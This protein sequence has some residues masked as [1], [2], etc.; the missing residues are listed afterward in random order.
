[1]KEQDV[2]LQPPVDLVGAADLGEAELGRVMLSGRA[3]SRT[4]FLAIA[5]R[6]VLGEAV[7]IFFR[8]PFLPAGEVL[9]EDKKVRRVTHG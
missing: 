9:A 2:A 8:L 7:E 1:V 5:V 6:I 3:M 4:S